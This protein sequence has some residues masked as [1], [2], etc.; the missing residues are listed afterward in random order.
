MAGNECIY[1]HLRLRIC[2]CFRMRVNAYMWENTFNTHIDMDIGGG[3]FHLHSIRL[4]YSIKIDRMCRS[5]FDAVHNC[6]VQHRE[7]EP[8]RYSRLSMLLS[9]TNILS[10][11]LIYRVYL[12]LYHHYYLCAI[13]FFSF[14]FLLL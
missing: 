13:F 11:C 3:K 1:I 12:V 8:I 10:H 2:E 5:L 7:L 14:Q 9:S 6:S 4:H